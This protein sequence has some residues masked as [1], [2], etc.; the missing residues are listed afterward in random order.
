MAIAV[1]CAYRT[2]S[3]LAALSTADIISIDLF[4]EENGKIYFDRIDKAEI[5]NETLEK[6][7]Q[8]W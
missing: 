8:R 5:H 3:D 2:I 6:W 4:I 1:M 7:R